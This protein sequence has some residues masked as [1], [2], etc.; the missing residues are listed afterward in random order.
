MEAR[1]RILLT[2]IHVR[3]GGSEQEALA[4]CQAA[5]AVLKA[6]GDLEGLAE[7]WKLAG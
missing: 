6:E 3:R 2:E 1:I 7:A 5:A 4:D